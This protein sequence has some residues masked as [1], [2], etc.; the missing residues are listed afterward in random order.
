MSN[1]YFDSLV[2]KPTLVGRWFTDSPKA[3]GTYIRARGP[4][5]NVLAVEIPKDKLVELQAANHPEANNMDIEGDNYIIPDELLPNARI[6][7]L[8]VAS[9][10]PD[11]FLFKHFTPIRSFVDGIVKQLQE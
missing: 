7:P 5:G 10:N 4:G 6:F 11:K 3:L 8:E 9:E 1:K 2:S